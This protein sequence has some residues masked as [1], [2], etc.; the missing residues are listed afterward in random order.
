MVH[1]TKPN[2]YSFS[3]SNKRYTLYPLKEEEKKLTSG[4]PSDK[5]KK[6]SGY[7]STEKFEAKSNQMGIV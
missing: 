1:K 3:K 2:T 5:V 6:I 4:S 7:L